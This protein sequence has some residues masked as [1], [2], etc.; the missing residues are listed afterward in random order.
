MAEVVVLDRLQV[1]LD[2]MLRIKV[3][4]QSRKDDGWLP[5]QDDET[6]EYTSQPDER[7]CHVCEGF[8][9]TMEFDGDELPLVFP[10]LVQREP[11]SYT[12]VRPAVHVTYPELIWSNDPDA[13]GGCRCRI[14][15]VNPENTLAARLAEE[16]REV[17]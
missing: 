10:D 13:E 8:A 1:I 15:W 17:V 7:V 11:P 12:L 3:V 5:F 6:W 4:I 16:L 14:K 9:I 2:D